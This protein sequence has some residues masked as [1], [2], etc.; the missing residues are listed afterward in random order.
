[1][2]FF[3]SHSP[4]AGLELGKGIVPMVSTAEAAEAPRTTPSAP[5]AGFTL[6]IVLVALVSL[7]G[8]LTSLMPLRIA[9]GWNASETWVRRIPFE[10]TASGQPVRLSGAL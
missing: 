6:V 5:D 8:L 7:A 3:G 2:A 10:I 9:I 4:E 1:L